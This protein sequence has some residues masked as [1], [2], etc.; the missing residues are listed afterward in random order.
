[1]AII[2]PWAEIAEPI[3]RRIAQLADAAE[4][5]E[6]VWIGAGNGRSVLWWAERYRTR[7]EGLHPDARAVE[8]AERAARRSGLQEL[9]GFQ[10]AQPS[11]LPH[12]GQV[13]DV[14]V[15]NF[16]QLGPVDA[17]ATARQAARVARPMGT[18][19]AIVPTWRRQAT[20]AERE[21]AEALGVR[22]RVLMEWKGVFRDAGVVELTAEEVAADEGWM[23]SGWVGLLLRAWRVARWRGVRA[24][25][26][27]PF[28]TFR[29]MVLG[30]ALGLSLLK[31]VRWPHA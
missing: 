29:R 16:L 15:V 28:R 9:V 1:M 2:A 23:L 26:G 13:F 27:R 21:A 5:R 11:D 6:T 24:L 3:H 30:R 8:Y 10:Q 31:G 20:E 19:V 14:T 18:V 7:T 17:V 25:L 22:P 12:E 4:G